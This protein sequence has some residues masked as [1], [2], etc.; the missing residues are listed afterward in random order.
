MKT[1]VKFKVFDMGDFSLI[2]APKIASRR[3]E[4]ISRELCNTDENMFEFHFD[5][6]GSDFKKWKYFVNDEQIDFDFIVNKLKKVEYFVIRNPYE[7]CFSGFLHHLHTNYLVNEKVIDGNYINFWTYEPTAE[8]DF[9]KDVTADLNILFNPFPNRIKLS[10]LQKESFEENKFYLKN[11]LVEWDKWVSDN[12]KFAYK[13]KML[14]S[15][16]IS[17]DHHSPY[18]VLY[19]KIIDSPLFNKTIKFIKMEN[20]DSFFG[21]DENITDSLGIFKQVDDSLFKKFYNSSSIYREEDL[22]W[23]TFIQKN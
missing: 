11:W 9:K 5:D 12:I 2:T 17:D 16:L 18:L 3:M 13:N 15:Y 19:K 22:I 4:G 7:R 10:M 8:F 23:N 21:V 20:I 14:E 6:V 1:F